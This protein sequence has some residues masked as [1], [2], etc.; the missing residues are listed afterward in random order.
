MT[1][2]L[3]IISLNELCDKKI[4]VMRSQYVGTEE[5]VRCYNCTGLD[6]TCRGYT[7]RRSQESIKRGSIAFRNFR[8]IY[9]QYGR[10]DSN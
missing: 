2:K 8:V 10:Q 1:E 6:R 4:S 7:Q 9:P 5:Q 3:E